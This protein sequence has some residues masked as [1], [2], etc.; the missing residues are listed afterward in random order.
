MFREL[1]K[2]TFPYRAWELQA[3]AKAKVE[4]AEAKVKAPEASAK[5]DAKESDD[6]KLLPQALLKSGTACR[7]T[8]YVVA[9]VGSNFESVQRGKRRFP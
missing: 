6:G 2:S 8:Y 1:L 5:E 7:N 4:A 9:V 3:K